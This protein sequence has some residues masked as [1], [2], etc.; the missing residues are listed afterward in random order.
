MKIRFQKIDDKVL[1]VYA[2]ILVA[3]V[4]GFSIYYFTTVMPIIAC[5]CGAFI[6]ALSGILKEFFW[7]KY[8]KKGTFDKQDMFMTFWGSLVGS[9]ALRVIIDLWE[10]YS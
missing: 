8:L 5:I 3:I 2:G 9:V 10:K 6:G 1:H 7:D 4:G